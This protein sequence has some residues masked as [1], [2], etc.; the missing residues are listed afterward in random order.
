MDEPA[1]G[2]VILGVAPSI[3]GLQALRRAVA[4]ARRRGVPLYAVRAWQFPANWQGIDATRWRREIAQ[5]AQAE[6]REAF[7][8]GLGGMPTDVDVRPVVVEGMPHRVLVV[9]AD[10]DTDLLVVGVRARRH[11][12]FPTEIGQYCHRHAICSV[13]V[14]PPPE[15]AA[16]GRPSALARRLRR[17]AEEYVYAHDRASAGGRP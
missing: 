10:R 15:L 7:E 14:V 17:E 3:A 11:R 2:R 6:V 5:E 12:W 8:L 9:Q 13:L 16:T 1:N 4:E